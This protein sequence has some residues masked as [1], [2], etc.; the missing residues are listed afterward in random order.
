MGYTVDV[1]GCAED[2]VTIECQ[3]LRDSKYT[4]GNQ[5]KT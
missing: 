5:N 4:A 2:M 3:K 1:W